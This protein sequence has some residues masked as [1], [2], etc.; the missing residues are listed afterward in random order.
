MTAQTCVVYCRVSSDRQAEEDKTSLDDQER[1]GRAKA[2][3]LGLS[4]LYVARHAESAWVLDKRSKFQVILVDARAGKFSVLIVDR[5]NRFSRSEDLSEPILVLRQLRELGIRV[6]FCDRQYAPDVL[7][8]MMQLF[9][10]GMSARDQEQRRKASYAGKV[11]RVTKGLHP[12]PTRRALYGYVWQPTQDGATKKTALLKDPG[13]AQAVVDRIWR[14]FLHFTPTT[15]QPRPTLYGIK[16]LLNQEHVPPP[17]VY[18]GVRDKTGTRRNVWTTATLTKILHNGVYW[19]EPRPALSDSKYPDLQAPVPIPAYGPT[20]VTPQEAARVHDILAQNGA[21]GGRPRKRHR[22]TLL[23]GG[24]VRC[25]YCGHPLAPMGVGRRQ[26]DGTR[27]LYYR[28]SEQSNHGREVCQGTNI[29]AE[30]LDWAVIAT[31]QEHL[32]Y[33]QFLERLFAAWEADGSAAHGQVRIAQA[34]YD[35]TYAQITNLAQYAA[36]TPPNSAAGAALQLQLDQAN[37]LLPGLAK[38]VASAKADAAKVRGSAALRDELQEWFAAWT[39]GF[40]MLSRARQRE[41]LFATHACVTL[42]RSKDRTPRA[43][44]LIGLPTDVLA[45]P[46]APEVSSTGDGFHLPLDLAQGVK[47]ASYA[48]DSLEPLEDTPEQAARRDAWSQASAGEVMAAVL[49][50]LDEQHLVP[51]ETV[52][53]L[54]T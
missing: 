42:W 6:E 31:L 11:G 20:Y 10:L 43:D 51:T 21:H 34:A 28:C 45:L 39:D 27:K 5:M 38:R 14:Y 30:V 2:A 29:R 35:E 26:A 41:F 22:D 19:G 40:T 18:Q 17:L 32:R 50:E 13:S 1:R 46:P 9:E 47:L 52:N 25:A 16:T 33:G 7:G 48:R 53:S 23:H 24:L 12:I 36:H 4:V 44:L 8:Q 3:E 54:T 15:T 49:D 37:A